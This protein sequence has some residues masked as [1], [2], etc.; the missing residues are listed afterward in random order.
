MHSLSEWGRD[1][2]YEDK[3]CFYVSWLLYLLSYA[4]KELINSLVLSYWATSADKQ[5][6]AEVHTLGE[7]FIADPLQNIPL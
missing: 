7:G 3:F 5:W 4:D 6:W 1:I 2:F